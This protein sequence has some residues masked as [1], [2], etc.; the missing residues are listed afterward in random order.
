M[1]S[2]SLSSLPPELQ[3]AVFRSLDNFADVSALMR[4]N[5]LFHAIWMLHMSS[6]SSAVLPRVIDCLDNAQDLLDTQERFTLRNFTQR[7]QP[8][9][10]FKIHRIAQLLSNQRIAYEVGRRFEAHCKVSSRKSGQQFV[11]ENPVNRRWFMLCY[12]HIWT[13]EDMCPGLNTMKGGL[14]I[15]LKNT[16]RSQDLHVLLKYSWRCWRSQFH[17]SVDKTT[18]QTTWQ[19]EDA[20]FETTGLLCVGERDSPVEIEL[21]RSMLGFLVRDMVAQFRQSFQAI[22]NFSKFS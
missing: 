3:L 4:T 2:P 13:F 22:A 19:V 6:I 16:G 9:A 1:S 11:F 14:Y 20:S 10:P 18:W 5:Q 15:P 7:Q 12:Y 17:L 21:T 8:V